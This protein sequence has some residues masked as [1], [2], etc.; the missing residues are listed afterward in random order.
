MFTLN[1]NSAAIKNSFFHLFFS[2]VLNHFFKFLNFRT[3]EVS[4]LFIESEFIDFYLRK[5]R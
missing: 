4:N 2:N 5:V 3:F 1:E